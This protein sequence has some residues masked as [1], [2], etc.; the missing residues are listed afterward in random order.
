MDSKKPLVSVL[1]S[2]HNYGRFIDDCIESLLS[3]TFPRKDME[4]I[5]V[6]DGSTDDTRDRIKKYHGSI[7][8]I[9]QENKGQGASVNTGF[10]NSCGEIIVLMDAD[11]YCA[12]NKIECI[13]DCYN[14]YNCEVLFHNLTVVGE[15]H[16]LR[17]EDYNLCTAEKIDRD[18]YRFTLDNIIKK[19][20]FP[21]QP[22]T[23]GHS[24]KRR[25]FAKLLPVPEEYISASDMYLGLYVLFNC[26]IYYFHTS[27]G[28][29]RQHS[30]SDAHSRTKKE[31]MQ[32]NI[33]DL[34]L[35]KNELRKRHGVKDTKPFIS[36]L[37]NRLERFYF[38]TALLEGNIPGAF[39]HLRN[40]RPSELMVPC[41]FAKIGLVIHLMLPRRWAPRVAKV[42]KQLYFDFSKVKRCGR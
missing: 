12:K 41:F 1:I 2:A 15:G 4:I 26:D 31:H 39:R 6:D 37:E 21:P 24:Y 33:R 22:P 5:V 29:Y 9:Y 35:L 36:L 16:G 19:G 17:M 42:V 40:Y 27:L 28:Y 14:K 34:C 32:F 8:Y 7:K 13:V 20:I 18:M 11:D 25:V 30:S 10:Q 23:S 38:N 3:Q